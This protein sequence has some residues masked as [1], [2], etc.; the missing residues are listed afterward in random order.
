MH[1]DVMASKVM[2]GTEVIVLAAGLQPMMAQP[3]HIHAAACGMPGHIMYPL[4]DL[5]ADAQG[6]AIAGTAIPDV[7]PSAG[8]SVHI[9]LANM[10][11]LACGTLTGGNMTSNSSPGR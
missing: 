1:F 5:L 3:D 6:R 10:D 11:P 4:T 2:P 9:H 7:V 8:V